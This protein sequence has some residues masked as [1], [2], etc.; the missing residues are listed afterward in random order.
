MVGFEEL[1]E[2]Y[3]PEI[4]AIVSRYTRPRIEH[5]DLWQEACF[6]LWEAYPRIDYSKNVRGFV[7][8]VVSRHLRSVVDRYK[9]DALYYAEPFEEVDDAED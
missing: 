1:L 6:A 7:R 9:R 5:D 4:E 2:A 3:R 8:R